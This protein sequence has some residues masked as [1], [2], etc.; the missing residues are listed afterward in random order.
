MLIDR[1]SHR[2]E[3]RQQFVK[4]GGQAR[5]VDLDRRTGHKRHTVERVRVDDGL[6]LAVPHPDRDLAGRV[7]DKRRH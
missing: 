2:A 1:D 6:Q 5:I 7:G 4:D 3:G